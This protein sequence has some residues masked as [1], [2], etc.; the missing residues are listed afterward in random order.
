MTQI[1]VDERPAA[2]PRCCRT[3]TGGRPCCRTCRRGCGTSSLLPHIV[4]LDSAKT[5]A[6]EFGEGC[7]PNVFTTLP[8]YDFVAQ[9]THDDALTTPFIV[10]GFNP[11]DLWA[12]VRNTDTKPIDVAI[13]ANL[14]RRPVRQTLTALANHDAKHR[15]MARLQPSGST[16]HT[17][18]A[19]D[20]SGVRR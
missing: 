3:R 18:R 15:R 17:T 16:T 13:N 20:S 1:R 7:D 4:D 5:L 19:R 14:S 2:W 12:D 10:R 9:V 11:D 8:K 6:R